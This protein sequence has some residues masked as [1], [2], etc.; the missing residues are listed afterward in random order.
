MNRLVILTGGGTAGHVTPNLALVEPLRAKGFEVAYMGRE[1]GMERGLAEGAGLPYFPIAAGR[2]HRYFD[3]E[4]LINPFR[5]IKGMAQAVRILRREKPCVVFAKGG[6][7]SVPVVMAARMAG[8][9]VVLHECDYTPGLAN[10]LCIPFAKTICTNFEETVAY[11]PKKKAVY[12]GTPIRAELSQGSRFEGY[13]LTGF[14]EN[15]PVLL[16]MGGST[17]AGA[18]NEGVCAALDLLLERY[19]VLH[20]CGRGNRE[21]ALERPGY[22]QLEYANQELPHLYAIA[23]VMLSRAGANSLA[24]ILMLKIPAILVPLPADVS[25]GDQILNAGAFEKRGYSYVLPQADITPERL[26]QAVDTVQEHRRDYI[27]AMSGQY[28][29]TGTEEVVRQICL[30]AGDKGENE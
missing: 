7:V 15:K 17:G 13:R 8:I 19:Q 11:L 12:T 22:F 21:E 9:P 1:N 27:T 16:V 5:N 29:K 18:L 24:E 28:V 4:N 2:L 6:F 30:A 20:L 25:R 23:D 3:P 14:T 10:K 26:V